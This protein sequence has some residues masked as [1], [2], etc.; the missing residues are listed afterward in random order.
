MYTNTHLQTHLP[1]PP[2]SPRLPISPILPPPPPR[3]SAHS[4]Q[5]YLAVD[6]DGMASTHVID[7]TGL[8]PK[9]WID[10]YRARS[11]ATGV[12]VEGIAAYDV[13]STTFFVLC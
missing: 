1:L 9:V 8:D 4:L 3:S 10:K 2:P 11:G 6:R 5:G 12:T 13:S 7:P